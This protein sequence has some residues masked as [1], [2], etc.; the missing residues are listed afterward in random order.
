MSDALGTPCYYTLVLIADGKYPGL[1][2]SSMLTP[3]GEFVDQT[4][5]LTQANMILRR[6]VFYVLLIWTGVLLISMIF[7]VPETYHPV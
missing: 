1:V 2:V 4:F 6:W 5:R 7:L 3:T